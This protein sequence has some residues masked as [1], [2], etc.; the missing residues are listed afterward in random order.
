MSFVPRFCWYHFSQKVG[1]WMPLALIGGQVIR[2][3]VIRS[4]VIRSLVIRGQLTQDYSYGI[5]WSVSLNPDV[6][7]QIKVSKDWSFGKRL[8]QLV[9]A[10]L[11]PEVR[12]IRF[13]VAPI[14][15]WIPNFTLF[16]FLDLDRFLFP[17]SPTTS[18]SL[19]LGDK[20]DNPVI[21]NIEVSDA[22]I[23]LKPQINCR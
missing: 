22:A 19:S 8:P 9:K 1:Y 2:S 23:L 18:S 6:T 11:A 21:F 4:Q 3:Q 16:D 12:N 10:F 17:T 14:H 20:S 15:V 13:S 5:A 7:F